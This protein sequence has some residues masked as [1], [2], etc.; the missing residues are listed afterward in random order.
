MVGLNG[1]RVFVEWDQALERPKGSIFAVSTEEPLRHPH[2]GL[3]VDNAAL[4]GELVP[5]TQ[6]FAQTQ[7]KGATAQ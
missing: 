5:D 4:L 3:S 7:G 2:G 6:G 1:L